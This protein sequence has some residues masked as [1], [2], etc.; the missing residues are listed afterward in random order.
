M[1]VKENKLIKELL[2]RHIT[3]NVRGLTFQ[4]K[5]E[6]EGVVLDIL[7][8]DDE[9]IETTYNFFDEFGIENVKWYK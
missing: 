4:M 7:D 8:E 2:K 9:V 5:M 6:D 1:S 3:L